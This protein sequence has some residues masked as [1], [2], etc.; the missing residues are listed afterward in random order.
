VTRTHLARTSLAVAVL[1]VATACSTTSGPTP[2]GTTSSTSSAG[3]SGARTPT[4]AD[5]AV[6]DTI[7][8]VGVDPTAGTDP[9][10][11]P[12][13]TLTKMPVSV[14]TT[15]VKVL[16]PGS[17]VASKAGDKVKIRQVLYL[18]NAGVKLDSSYG[19]KQPASFTLSGA[20]TI[21]GLIAA[22]TG[23]QK[24][25]RI[26]FV[27]P[28]AEAFGSQGRTQIGISATDNLV[29]VAD[30]IE[31]TTPKPV[32]DKAEGTAVTPPPGLPA[33]T[34]DDAKGPTVTIPKTA[35]PTETVSQPLIE[36]SGA[37]VEAGQEITVHY[38]GVLW[39]DGSVFDTSWDNKTP[40]SFSIGT[41][42]VI[43]AWDAKLVGQKIGS[44]VLLIV[45]PKDGYGASGRP[46]TISG[47]DTMVFVVDILGA[48]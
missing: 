4:K 17:G 46:P 28:P 6:L 37:V 43:P 9:V 36:G 8:V 29:V 25:S 1:L 26:L 11:E 7:T 2:G 12:T 35:P 45:P 18:G 31:V 24:G 14:T 20:D 23:V 21:P 19:E 3:P 42:A 39:K 22:L 27:I 30:I 13:V 5:Q 38:T 34:F 33:V 48:S 32:L 47:T 40:A 10:A 16:R 41:G 44:R 15:T